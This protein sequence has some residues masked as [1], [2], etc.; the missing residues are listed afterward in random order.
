MTFR[1]FRDVVRLPTDLGVL[2]T[3]DKFVKSLL[4]RKRR[5]RVVLDIADGII[6]IRKY[7]GSTTTATRRRSPRRCVRAFA[8]S[9]S[10]F[11]VFVWVDD[12][13][14]FVERFFSNVFQSIF[15]LFIGACKCLPFFWWWCSIYLVNTLC[16]CVHGCFSCKN[17]LKILQRAAAD[18]RRPLPPPRER[19]NTR[20]VLSLRGLRRHRIH[21]ALFALISSKTF[22]NHFDALA[23]RSNSVLSF[24]TR[25]MTSEGA[26]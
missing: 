12:D 9:S 10:F 7:Y 25:S 20:G 1:E 11:F 17:I 2:T 24:F 26:S 5:R 13:R 4:R 18:R 16:V 6:I 19:T 21:A 8:H 14:K 3:R 15:F 22:C 23:S